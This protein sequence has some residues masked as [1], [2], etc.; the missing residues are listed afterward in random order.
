MKLFSGSSNTSLALEVG[1]SSAIELGTTHLD[2]FPNAELKV[3]VGEVSKEVALL[4]SF[5][6]PVNDNIIEFLLLTDALKRSGAEQVTAIIPWF[7]YSKQDKV[8]QIG[9]PLS[10]K[11]IARLIQTAKINSVITFNLHNPSIAGYFD[12]PVIDL[13]AFPLFVEHLQ[14]EQLTQKETVVVAPDAGSIKASTAMADELGLD[15]AYVNKRRDLQTGE[16]SINGMDKD[17]SGKDC[18]IFDDM[19]ATGSTMIKVSEFLK[20]AGARTVRIFATHHLYI[21]GVQDKLDSSIIDEVHVSNTIQKPQSLISDK[22][23]VHS[24]AS[25]LVER[26][27]SN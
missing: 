5:S 4:Q 25:I 27:S 20:E 10:V 8:F 21:P 16:V 17:I 6:Q 18:L 7:G 11:V 19:I 9:E 3:R 1:N 24:V 26:L 14:K 23:N 12:I 22:L 2:N 15:I 13:S